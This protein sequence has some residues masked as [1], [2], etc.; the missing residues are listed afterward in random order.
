MLMTISPSSCGTIRLF[1]PSII[2]FSLFFGFPFY[3]LIYLFNK[4]AQ[5]GKQIIGMDL[6]EVAPGEDDW[7]GNVGARMLYHMCGVWAQNNGL[8]VGKRITF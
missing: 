7:D 8:E 6:V 3:I 1:P 4:L 2:Y 5:S